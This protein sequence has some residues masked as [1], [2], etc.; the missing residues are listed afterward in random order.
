MGLWVEEILFAA[1]DLAGV[2]PTCFLL[3][4]GS[5]KIAAFFATLGDL[6]GLL[7]ELLLLERESE[8]SGLFTPSFFLGFRLLA[9]DLFLELAKLVLVLSFL[10]ERNILE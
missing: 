6:W 2:E 7:A 4:P 3:F 9:L 5:S 8:V 1:G 10:V